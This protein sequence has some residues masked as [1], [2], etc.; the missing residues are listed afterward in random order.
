VLVRGQAIGSVVVRLA[1]AH[2]ENRSITATKMAAAASEGK[3]SHGYDTDPITLSRFIMEEEHRDHGARADLAFILQSVTVASKVIASAVSRAGIQ[4]LYGMVGAVNVQ[5][6]DQKALDVLA[7]QIM[8]NVLTYSK[9]I[10]VMVSEENPDPIIVGDKGQL[11][12]KYAIVFDPLDGSSNIECNVSVGTIFGIYQ[13]SDTDSTTPASVSDVLQP[14]NKMVA[15]GYVLYSSSTV[16]VVST[17][18][19]VHSFTLDHVS[20]EFIMTRHDIKIPDEPKKIYSCNEGN[21]SKWDAP[22]QDFVRW[23]K[24]GPKPYAMRYVGSMVSDVHR[25]LLYG[26]IFF[27]PADASNKNG[28]LRLLYECFPMSFLIEKAGGMATTGMDRLLDIHPTDIHQRAPIFVGCK[29]DVQKV[30][31]LYAAHAAAAK[32]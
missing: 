32:K 15:A 7:N 22:T 25:T 18:E 23:C 19:G 4:G 29:R 16:L 27:Y 17:G 8:I 24:E 3:H 20:G 10:S 5:G 31:D 14:G 6:E 13:V 12:S 26:G 30:A 21:Y 28:K 9:K 1:S 11:S 2:W